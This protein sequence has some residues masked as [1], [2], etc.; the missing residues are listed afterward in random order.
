MTKSQLSKALRDRRPYIDIS[1]RDFEII[2][3]QIFEAMKYAMAMG[4]RI[5]IRGFGVF[6]VVE[7]LARE[8]RNPKTGQAVDLPARKLPFFKCGKEL[9]ERINN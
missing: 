6:A 7:R 2:V 4:E 5:E 1:P 9:K 3:D 8:G